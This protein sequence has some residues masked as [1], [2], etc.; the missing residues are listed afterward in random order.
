MT[1][2]QKFL[3]LYKRLETLLD[4]RYPY[5]DTS[6]KEYYHSLEKSMVKDA[7]ERAVAIDMC[8][9]L[10]NNLSHRN[11]GHLF[12]VTEDTIAFLEKEID[13]LENPFCAKDIMTP[14]ERIFSVTLN[15]NTIQ[16]LDEIYKNSYDYVPVLDEKEK[17]IGVFSLNCLLAKIHKNHETRIENLSTIY[18]Y[19]QYIGLDEQVKE[20][21]A[22]VS[23]DDDIETIVDV[24]NNKKDKKVVLLFV[25]NHGTN[26]E[27][28]RGIITPHDVINKAR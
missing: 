21:F 9:T 1:I 26:N 10:R 15:S 24:F 19:Y 6:V 25:T 16:V 23:I 3:E 8:R 22:F 20:K 2:N 12:N 5:A 7:K 28:I 18:D 13:I 17:V 14:R 4:M 27:K 11:V